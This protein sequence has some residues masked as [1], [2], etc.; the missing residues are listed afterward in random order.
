ML[1]EKE[2][3]MSTKTILIQI[4][5]ITTFGGAASAQEASAPTS[6]PAP[7]RQSPPAPAP[8]PPAPE[9]AVAPPA[10]T[11]VASADRKSVV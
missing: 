9:T 11:A 4:L 3:T 6:A 7:E 5:A 2:S 8:I 1:D 10:E